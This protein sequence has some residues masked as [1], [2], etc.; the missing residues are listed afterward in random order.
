[1]EESKYASE[2]ITANWGS[3]KS[4]L[5]SVYNKIDKKLPLSV[6]AE[7]GNYLTETRK[8]YSKAK[9]FF[10][11]NQSV[12][13]YDYY[14]PTA[15]SVNNKAIRK[16]SLNNLLE[17]SKRLLVRGSGGSGKSVLMRHL[18]LNSI[19][20]F[21]Y[22]PVLIELR[23]LNSKKV[24]LDDIIDETLDAFGFTLSPDY[25]E[26]AKKRG[27]FC[28]FFDGFDEVDHDLRPEL[29]KVIKNIS[30]KYSECPMILSSRPEEALDGIDEFST[31]QILPLSL[32]DAKSLIEKLPYDKSI[33]KKFVKK[34][35]G[36]LF[37]KHQ[38]FLSN[39]LLLSIMLLTYGEN[40]E[41]PN[42]LSI[43]YNQAFEALFQRHDANKSGYY[44]KRLTQL[45]IQDFSRVFSL[46]CLQTYERRIFKMP[47][48]ECYR[49]IE[50]ASERLNLNFKPEDYLND[51]L[52][53]AC[54]LI[55]DGLDVAFSHR[56]FQE[57]FVALH[58]SNAPSDIQE[59]LIDRYWKNIVSDDV[60]KLLY[61][62]NPELVE[63]K[64]IVPKMEYLF[65][66][67]SVENEVK[68]ENAIK[69]LKKY[70]NELHIDDDGLSAI[71]NDSQE[72]YVALVRLT[73]RVCEAYKLPSKEHFEE[74][75]EHL[76]SKYVGEPL[77][78]EGANIRYEISTL[79]DD[80][81]LLN[82][83]VLSEGVFSLS[84]LRSVYFNYK[85]LKDKYEN[86][87]SSLDE[88]LGI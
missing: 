9:S 43:F 74:Y 36:E 76:L 6:K 28:F 62:I 20:N 41:I 72:K 44:R 32:N 31:V 64:L 82:D 51:L 12:D 25:I 17:A 2:F 57:Y 68:F 5:T 30:R 79:P 61:E 4:I 49:Y 88:L 75:N 56:S 3:I 23:E 73:D 45:D 67:I 29:M 26:E 59:K 65:E 11:R 14:V 53:A 54:L 48:T 34:L 1:M 13:L 87:E 81:E 58:I 42:K 80:Y 66:S 35:E 46:F 52:S 38:S 78:R 22:V 24:H 21:S 70:Y 83:I 19:D 69:Y 33:K 10:I 27:H 85:A 16:P 40:A 47:K 7:Y 39:P 71:I 55:E 60:I 84:Y 8:K 18:F 37:F 63:Q 77:E 50:R 15:V 86:Y